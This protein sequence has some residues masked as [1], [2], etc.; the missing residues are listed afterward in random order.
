M[1]RKIGLISGSG[2]FP[3][4]LAD[5]ARREGF[6]VV[7]VAHEGET[8][9]ELERSVDKIVWLKL[10]QLG[11]LIDTFKNEDVREVV[12]AG[13]IDKKRIYAKVWPDLKAIALWSRLKNRL[14]DGI[15]RA[16]AGVLEEEGIV[17]R[18][19]TLFLQSLM[20]PKG[21]LTRRRPADEELKDAEF[22]WRVA[23]EIG[24]MDIGQC[25]VVKNLVVLAVEAIEGTD[26]TIRRGGLLAKKGA[27]VIK[28]LKPNQDLRFDLPAVG[29]Q[30]ILTMQEVGASC[31]A[32]ESGSVIMFEKQEMIAEAERRRIAIIAL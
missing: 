13:G 1:T 24:R 12:M 5:A 22:G 21:V 10:G 7:A 26:E 16:L 6:T 28:V 29:L 8:S 18:E 32:I 9:P 23:K 30:T 14:D 31:L 25:I 2:T 15:L 3:V 19:S 4:I 17:V 11:K 20:A 27:V